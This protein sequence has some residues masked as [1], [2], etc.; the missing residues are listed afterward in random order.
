MPATAALLLLGAL[1]GTAQADEF[2]CRQCCTAS[3]LDSCEPAL[4]V[5]GEDSLVVARVQGDFEVVGLWVAQCDGTAFFEIDETARF[6]HSPT[7]G[8]VAPA[9]PQ[10]LRCFLETCS[11]PGGTCPQAVGRYPVLRRCSDGAPI[12]D[13][14]LS[15]KGQ[16]PPSGQGTTTV[17]INGRAVV[18]VEAKPATPPPGRVGGVSTAAQPTVT[19]PTVTQPAVTQPAVTPPTQ[20]A[21]VAQPT[22]VAQPAPQ[23]TA[24]TIPS[25][26]P[27]AVAAPTQVSIGG[28]PDADVD[29]SA[30]KRPPQTCNTAAA[31]IKESTRHVDLGNEAEVSAQLGKAADEYR[32][33]ITMHPC[34]AFA[35]VALGRL[36]L[37]VGRPDQAV[38]SLEIGLEL[39][40]NHYGAATELG[41][42][43]EAL[44][45]RARAIDAYN[46]ALAAN[47]QHA[48]ARQ[49]LV[50][51]GA[52]PR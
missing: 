37:R 35:W 13:Q 48:P 31:L 46:A 18:A 38:Q 44:G 22:P 45:Q 12:S 1:M 33:A 28:Q 7:T 34:N 5:V 2:S 50:R 32:A 11:L 3:G 6:D 4:R 27:A 36:A 43:Y 40:P 41:R 10:L 17:M 30:P 15:R 39:A 20:A 14:D 49:A 51:L 16:K 29:V 9:S 47:P 21:P 42:A 19:Q 26:Q 23:P 25:A 8:E 24:V 52:T